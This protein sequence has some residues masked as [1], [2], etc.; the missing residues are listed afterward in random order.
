[1]ANDL[2]NQALQS[3]GNPVNATSPQLARVIG[4]YE[5]AMRAS[6]SVAKEMSQLTGVSDVDT[7]FIT[8]TLPEGYDPFIDQK[9]RDALI[10]NDASQD[11]LIEAC[12]DEGAF[13]FFC[14]RVMQKA[15][16]P[17]M[18][19]TKFDCWLQQIRQK[20]YLRLVSGG[21]QLRGDARDKAAR[22][23][24]AMFCALSW[25]SYLMM[26]HCY[27][28]LMFL[29]SQDLRSGSERCSPLEE[30]LF[31]MRHCQV[32][33]LAGLP[34]AF[35]NPAQLQWIIRC[36][37]RQENLLIESLHGED[38][39]EEFDAAKYLGQYREIPELLGV[40]GHLVRER[41]EADRR[42][43]ARARQA[44]VTS[45]EPQTLERHSARGGACQPGSH[46]PAE[47]LEQLDSLRSPFCPQPG[48]GAVMQ[49]AE[50]IDLSDPG[51][52]AALMYCPRCDEERYYTLDL[53]G[54]SSP[55]M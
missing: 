42:T 9:V 45:Q 54:M 50:R 3:T 38:R 29:I 10:Y 34:L 49:V 52:V 16:E 39:Q 23:A 43:K 28:V 14:G 22:R 53:T 7:L 40:F 44:I 11:E 25:A 51:R 1:M 13:T 48:C 41:R 32:D 26:A 47:L 31:R 4:F 20:S 37:F 15:L 36:L 24:H 18:T 27:G 33:Y 6:N 19:V 12:A 8:R 2:L 55:A 17:N 46:S 5:T 35:L 30:W 21:T